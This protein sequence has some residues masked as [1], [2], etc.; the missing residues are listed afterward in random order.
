[1]AAAGERRQTL[2]VLSI[3]SC[4]G[5]VVGLTIASDTQR[6][7]LQGALAGALI[8]SLTRAIGRVLRQVGVSRWSFGAYVTVST[9]VTALA[10]CAGLAAAALPWLLTEGAGSWRSYVIPFLCAVAVS[11]GFTLWFALDRLLGGDV[12]VGLLTGRYHHPRREERIFL[13]ADLQGSTG[14]AERL[15]E[16]R[17]HAFLNRAFVDVADPVE[18]HAGVIYQY[19]G[20]EVVVTW[21]LQRGLRDWNCLRCAHAIIDT[22]AQAR[23]GYEQEF[24]A[25]PRFR[26]ALHC[27][28]VV[29]GE[30]GDLK[31]EI[32]FSGDTVNT[33]A[34]IES[35]A[36]QLDRNVIVSEDVLRQAP[37][38]PDLAAESIG[39]YTLKGKQRELEL[40]SVD[41][42]ASTGTDAARQGELHGR[43]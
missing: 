2:T 15:G 31:R 5:A 23:V 11:A 27:G 41:R 35:V 38:P 39:T 12:L 43:G 34:R 14:L 40:M 24:G 26:F 30:L 18:R 13:F 10:I 29:A 21:P 16:L 17:Y 42:V 19:V 33:T 8:S 7:L 37:L 6:G 32:V 20:D 28:P 9:L 25:V 22:L 4:A 36:K 3:S 1:M